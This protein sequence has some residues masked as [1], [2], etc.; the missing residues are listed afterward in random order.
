MEPSLNFCLDLINQMSEYGIEEVSLTGGEPLC[1]KD[2]FCIVDAL[3]RKNIKLTEINTNG[4]LVNEKFLEKLELRKIRP[5]FSISFD[6]LNFHDWFRGTEGAQYLAEN[7]FY[8]LNSKKFETSATICMHK[9]NLKTLE[10]NIDFLTSLGVKTVYTNQIIVTDTCKIKKEIPSV[11]ELYE[12]YLDYIPKFFKRKSPINL[13][14]GGFF[15]CKKGSKN[16]SIP[17]KKYNKTE[18][19][20]P[21]QSIC[22]HAKNKV[23]IAPDTS[24]LPCMPLLTANNNFKRAFLLKVSFKEAIE[25]YFY[26]KIMNTQ[27]SDLFSKNSK[28]KKCKKKYVCAGG[29]RAFALNFKKNIFDCDE[30]SCY[31]FKNNYEQKIKMQL[32]NI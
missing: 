8:L 21:F 3:S 28:C 32:T 15:I 4:S 31:F 30:N 24:V 6:G 16:Y 18:K 11:Y 23:Y 13:V 7:A 25:S 22:P 20:L 2:F 26:K 5:E 14:L 27:L 12:A 10:K 1:R 9:R 17:A 29:C 19:N